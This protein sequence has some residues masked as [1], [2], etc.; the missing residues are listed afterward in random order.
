MRLI[1]HWALVIL[2]GLTSATVLP[3]GAFAD[4]QFYSVAPALSRVTVED[5]G[6]A[7][8]LTSIP[9]PP[10][11]YHWIS[12]DS[13][14][15]LFPGAK[16][17]KVMPL[18]TLGTRQYRT[19]LVKFAPG[20]LD[21]PGLFAWNNPVGATIGGSGEIYGNHESLLALRIRPG[22]VR[23]GLVITNEL[24]AQPSAALSDPQLGKKFDLILH[25]NGAIFEGKFW[26]GYLEW[27]VVNPAVVEAVTADPLILTGEMK[28]FFD[29]L[30]VMAASGQR[31]SVPAIEVLAGPQHNGIVSYSIDAQFVVDLGTSITKNSSRLPKWLTNGW[32]KLGTK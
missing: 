18:K 12:V 8:P 29:G 31:H 4:S 13:M 19:L 23:V 1:A 11:L 15:R 30:K 7:Q 21:V 5:V 25:A 14:K 9:P 32:T 16:P 28:P 6:T 10:I 3:S 2:L 22:K 17:P 26:P 24:D 27:A 20:F